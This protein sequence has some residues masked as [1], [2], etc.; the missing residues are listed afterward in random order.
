[1]DD[2][3]FKKH[4]SIGYPAAEHD[5]DFLTECFVD[6]GDLDLLLDCTSPKSII[7]GRTG[8][9]KSALVYKI[10]T[11]LEHAISLSPHSL[12][13]NF[14]ATNNVVSFFEEAGVNLSPFYV[15]LWKHLLVVELLKEKFHITNEDSHRSFMRVIRDGFYGNNKYKDMAIDY[16]ENWGNKFWQTTEERLHELTDKVESSLKGSLGVELLGTQLSAEGAR[17]LSQEQKRQVID[18]GLDAVSK[19]QIRELDNLFSILE[20]NVFN[21]SR[22]PYYITIDMLDED[23][24]D[25]RIKF[26][27]IRALIDV[28]KRF[29]SLTNVK[30]ILALRQDLL[31]KVM[32]LESSAAFQEEK[33]KPLFLNLNWKKQELY[34]LIESRMNA[35]LKRRYT[36]KIV[37]FYDFFPAKINDQKTFDYMLDRTFMRPRDIIMFVNDCLELAEARSDICLQTIKD[38][39]ANYS[40]ER[41]KSLE[42]EWLMFFP[43]LNASS[44]I[45]YGM[46]N[47]FEVST[48]TEDYLVNKFEEIIPMISNIDSDPIT[49]SLNNLY[50]TSANFSSIR[51]FIIREFYTMGFLGIKTNPQEPVRWSYE[52]K[53]IAI[54]AGE[55]RPSSSLYIHPMFYR[56]LGV[57]TN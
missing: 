49:R 23:W 38:A 15:L 9:G 57:K 27:L 3:V 16:L 4:D 10:K 44:K 54:N 22:N 33:Y 56:A 32:Y 42:Y 25:D 50:S 18:H 11:S 34:E 1:M 41:M 46:N 31:H 48:L 51:N 7:V 35:L 8:T 14:I 19:V 21:D 24:A 20:E 28:V 13:L 40:K 29:R 53:N 26:K 37:E 12:S 52:G 2:F 47:H 6:N 43:N 39:E 17:T 45:F 30:I 55:I 5:K 36:K